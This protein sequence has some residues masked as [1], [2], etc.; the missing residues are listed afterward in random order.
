MKYPLQ[1]AAI[2]ELQEQL[3]HLLGK[4]YHIQDAYQKQL[5]RQVS[6]NAAI[7]AVLEQMDREYDDRRRRNTCSS[8]DDS[9]DQ[10]SFVSALDVSFK[11]YFH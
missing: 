7:D 5:F 8:L 3:H 9:S 4:S 11:F 1:D 10:D 2:Q 6:T